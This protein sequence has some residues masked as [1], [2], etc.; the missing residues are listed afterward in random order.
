M[1]AS[2]AFSTQ[3]DQVLFLIATGSASELEMMYL[4][5]QH[6][7]AR[8]TSPAVAL[9]HLAVQVTVASC[10]ESELPVFA[11][12]L[13]FHEAFRATSDRKAS[14]CGLGRNL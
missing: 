11:A 2:V 5:M 1:H 4:Q 14:C 10:I 7:T 9:Q 6:A 13:L 3:A 8:L 12:D